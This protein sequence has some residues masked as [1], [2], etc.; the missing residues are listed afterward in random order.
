MDDA[1][2]DDSWVHLDRTAFEVLSIIDC[3]ELTNEDVRAAYDKQIGTATEEHQRRRLHEAFRTIETEA[4]RNGYRLALSPYQQEQEQGEDGIDDTLEAAGTEG[5]PRT[6]QV[7]SLHNK[8]IAGVLCAPDAPYAKLLQA[9]LKVQ[10]NFELELPQIIVCGTEN[11]GKSS[12]LERIAMRDIFPRD[13]RF[14]TRMPV[15]LML[16]TSRHQNQVTIRVKNLDTGEI[17]RE[18]DPRICVTGDQ[19]DEPFSSQVAELIREF[20]SKEHPED[21]FRHV[22]INREVQIEIRAP[23][24]PTIDLVD[25]PGM[26]TA[27]EAAREATM[28]ITKRMLRQEHVLVLAVVSARSESLH[29]N[30]IWPLLREAKK[31]TVVVL[32]R[33]DM[34][35]GEENL[36]A[37]LERD[38]AVMPDDVKVDCVVPVANRDT[39]KHVDMTS[40][41]DSFA[42]EVI[43]LR[44]ACDSEDMEYDADRHGM[45]GVLNA[46]NEMIRVYMRDQWVDAELKRCRDALK[47]RFSNLWDLGM[48]PRAIT[49][50]MVKDEIKRGLDVFM[51][52][53]TAKLLGEIDVPAFL[54]FMLDFPRSK[55]LARRA[56]LFRDHKAELKDQIVGLAYTTWD[57]YKEL[58]MREV[59]DKSKI[60]LKIGRFFFVRKHIENTL[61]TSFNAASEAIVEKAFLCA[62]AQLKDA[63]LK[64]SDTIDPEQI[65]SN[66]RESVFVS[67]AGSFSAEALSESLYSG[68]E[69]ELR[70]APKVLE[71]RSGIEEQIDAVYRTVHVLQE[72][73]DLEDLPEDFQYAKF[74]TEGG[75]TDELQTSLKEETFPQNFLHG[76]TASVL[77]EEGLCDEE[78]SV[79]GFG[80]GSLFASDDGGY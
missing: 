16:R 7:N 45:S 56:H 68:C 9:A 4:C 10:G 50:E 70:E 76:T 51:D 59:L 1:A 6:A 66:V 3:V 69:F 49:Q 62:A 41:R 26:V 8:G 72:L 58:V 19:T 38:P 12:T 5:E 64:K 60:P 44:K 32:T 27:P 55:T 47:V 48:T 18:T 42:Q 73:Q 75:I 15:R 29:N 35:G 80:V 39:R 65:W 34:P 40:L 25:L 74:L 37:R 33:V 31:P 77:H 11:Q 2:S 13:S 20:I 43:A 28:S 21:N 36:K 30:G 54:N 17:V 61:D 22:V 78:E 63:L 67:L 46:L 23:S 24:V 14:C 57:I 79:S 71:T 52:M 53:P